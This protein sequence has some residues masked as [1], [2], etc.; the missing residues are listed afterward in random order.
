MKRFLFLLGLTV[1]LTAAAQTAGNYSRAESAWI[2]FLNPTTV[3]DEEQSVTG[4]VM[5]ADG[6]KTNGNAFFGAIADDIQ[7]QLGR[8]PAQKLGTVDVVF[9]D[10]PS[11]SA[12]S[13]RSGRG[14]RGSRGSRGKG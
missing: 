4:K 7:H 6:Q 3:V 13:S 10:T 14:S 9:F 12:R 8:Y 2:H 11:G 1:S 5:L